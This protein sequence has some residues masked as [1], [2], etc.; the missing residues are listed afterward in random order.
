[1]TSLPRIYPL[2]HPQQRIFLVQQLNPGTPVWNV[3]YG[4]RVDGVFDRQALEAAVRS[5]VEEFDGLRV[6]ISERDGEVGHCIAEPGDIR[7][8]VITLEK[9]GGETQYDAWARRFSREPFWGFDKPLVQFVAARITSERWGLIVKLHH[10]IAD[11][12]G[13]LNAIS[14]V[15]E[16]Y[17]AITS[18]RAP[19]SLP[20]HS[21]CLA[22]LDY[23]N[24]YLA[25]QQVTVDRE[26]WLKEFAAVPD[27]IE[28]FPEQATPS[29]ASKRITVKM[30]DK[31]SADLYDFCDHNSTSP[32]RLLLASLYI[33]LARTSRT[34]DAVIGTALQN[35]DYP[36]M[37]D[38]VGMF[39]STVPI[40][41]T[42]PFES[43]FTRLLDSIKEKMSE[44]R[45]HERYPFDMLLHNIRERDG[46]VPELMQ[47]S[48]AQFMGKRFDSSTALEFQCRRAI[49]NP[50]NIYLLHG[51]KGERDVPVELIFDYQSAVFSEERITALAGHLCN[52][53]TAGIAAPETVLSS[54]NMLS[55]GEERRLLEQFNATT[56]EFPA[57]KTLHGLFEEQVMR[58]PD[59]PALV[60]REQSMSYA[61]LNARAD[62][63]A[64]MLRE[65]G[66]APDTIVGLLVDRSM[67]MIVG[68]LGI[69]K[70]GAGYAPID[71]QYPEDRIAY[72]LEDSQA[73]LLVTQ[74]HYVNK[75]GFTQKVINLDDP[76]FLSRK[77]DK[78]S[79]VGSP[80]NIACMIYTSGSTGNPKGVMLEQQ[81][82]VNIVQSHI[83]TRGMTE[84][85]R[86]AKLA[87]F[88][89]DASIIEIY[90]ALSVGA[91]LYIIP[92]EIRLNLVP[93][94]D[95][96][97][98]HGI[99]GAFFTTQLG[100][101]FMELFDNR[102]LRYLDVGGEKLRSFK[103]RNYQ[104]YN[105]YGP[106]ECSVYAT[107]FPVDREYA[108]IPIG[109]PLHN[110]CLYVVDSFNN[111]QPVGVPGELCI[112]GVALARGYWNLP[113]K[114][115]AA[116]V[117]NPFEPGQSRFSRLYRTGD[118]ARWL[119]DGTIEHLGRI[120]R[121][122]K[123]RGYRIEPGEIESAILSL[124]GVSECAVLDI[125]EPSGRVAL[126]AYVVA[127]RP[128]DG[129]TLKREI[130]TTLP[131]YMMPQYI[132]QMEAFPQTGSGKI[133]RKAFPKPEIMVQEETL[134]VAPRSELEER[135]AL[136]WQE[137]LK[138]Q[139][140]GIDDNF[141]SIGGQSLKAAFLLARMEKQVG[142]RVAMHEFFATPTIRE[143]SE[144]FGELEQSEV[145]RLEPASSAPYYP[146]TPSQEQLFILS[147]MDGIGISYNVPFRMVLDGLLDIARL[148]VALRHLLLRHESLRTLFRIEGNLPV[149][150]IDPRAR[151]DLRF[152]EGDEESVEQMARNFIRPFDLGK[153]PLFR[154]LLVKT[155]QQCH[156]LIMDLHH[157][158]CDGVSVSIL[159]RD[160]RSLYSGEEPPPLP[161]QFKDYA[162]WYNSFRDSEKA[163]RQGEFW[164]E[165]FHDPK[166][167]EMPTDYPRG[168]SASFEG[169]A[170][171]VVLE[172]DVYRDL[173]SLASSSGCTMHILLMAALH[174]L[175]GRYSRQ[176]DVT[177]GTTLAGRPLDET[178]DMIGMF[179]V[180]LPVRS[181]PKGGETFREFLGELKKTILSVHQ[182]QIYPMERLYET[183]NLRRGAGRHPL[184]DINLVLRNIDMDIFDADGV[185]GERFSIPTNTCKF[186]MSIAADELD[187]KIR[188]RIDYR[189]ALYDRSTVERFAGHYLNVLADAARNPDKQIADIAILSP[190]EQ[191][192][193]L[194]DFNP[195]P[196]PQPSWETV[197][198][199][200]RRHAAERPTRTALVAED[201]SLTYAELD[202]RSDTLARLLREKGV[203]TD[204]VT[205]IMADRSGMVVVAM[206]AI[207]KAGGA[208]TA[209][210]PKYPAERIRHIL[211]SADAQVLLGNS[212]V[213]AGV[214]FEGERIA[215][216]K[217]LPPFQGE[218]SPGQ[219]E[220]G[221]GGDVV[222]YEVSPSS[223]AYIIY[224]SGSTGKPKGV[225]VE[226]RSLVNFLNWYTTLHG[227]T[228]EDNSAAFASFSFD[229]C[230][231]QVWAPLVSGAALHVI[232]EELRLSPAEL[233]EYFETNSVT[234]AHFPTQF[235]EQFMAMTDNRS[236]KRLVVGGDALR[237]YRIGNYSIVNEYG[238]S[239]TTVASTAIT[240]DRQYA[241]VPIGKPA[242]NTRV[243]ILDS[244][245]KLQPVG[246]PGEICIAGSGLA[247]GYRNNPEQTAEKFVADPFAPGKIM[248]RTG[249]LGRWL[250]DGNLEFLG[251][252]DFQVKIRGFRIELS[253]IEQALLAVET[254]R[255]TVV[256]ARSDDDGNKY[257]C[258]YYEA[259][260]E[261][262]LT[263]LKQKLARS[264][265]DYMIPSALVW[266]AAMPINRNG[267]IDRP[268]LPD[269]EFSRVEGEVVPPG[270]PIEEDIAAAWRSVLKEWRGGI[271]DNFFEVGGDSLRA[272]ALVAQL[273]KNFNVRI[274]DI[275]A[276]PSI[277][278]QGRKL[279][280]VKDNLKQRLYR[281]KDALAAA[282]AARLK[283]AED[284][285]FKG[286]VSDY[287]KISEGF[288]KLDLTRQ[289]DYR[290]VLLTGSTGYLGCYILRELLTKR[291]CRLTL[292]IR[293]NSEIEAT[294]RLQGK[295]DYYFGAEFYQQHQARITVLAADL[296]K[297]RLGVQEAE[298]S[299]LA[300][301]I[302]C[303]IHAAANVRHYGLYEE[304]H[305]SNV[306]STE[307]LIE[308]ASEGVK[309]DIHHISTTST[310]QG[311]TDRPW[312]LFTED[313]LD[314]GQSPANVYV[315]SKLAAERLVTAAREKGINSCIH[316]VGNICYDS[317]SG[318]F[319]ENI[320]EN[321]FYQQVKGYADIGTAPD[322]GDERNLT[323][324]DR[325]AAAIVT[326]F[327]R[328]ELPDQIFHFSNPNRAKLSQLLPDRRLG[329]N[330][331]IV[332]QADFIDLLAE[333]FDIPYFSQ[334]IEN[335][336]LHQGWLDGDPAAKAT[337]LSIRTERTDRI[338]ELAGFSWPNPE[339][340]TIR[341]MILKALTERSQFLE[342]MPV[343]AH[344][345]ASELEKL[346]IHARPVWLPVETDISRE[347]EEEERIYAVVDGHLEAS[348]LSRDGWVG[349]IRL[350]SAGELIGKDALLHG[351]P[352]PVTIQSILDGVVLLEFE[353]ELLRSLLQDSPGFAL[354][355]AKTLSHSLN[356]MESLFVNMG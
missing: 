123:I 43:S 143:I 265:P 35:R 326:L 85:D 27:P 268:A 70:S 302:D 166:P 65:S 152:E 47:F 1:M 148:S 320:E 84:T 136:L 306:T 127:S 252:V 221:Q 235:A 251:R 349:T 198:H 114:T 83:M 315:K 96:Y 199:A 67:A 332:R 289:R 87:S 324:V 97:E 15:M 228:S 6:Y 91:T 90:P 217:Q 21:S 180:T 93:L 75:M 255:R 273:Q 347:G 77:S 178:A 147:R 184:F 187:G 116:F 40:R 220:S 104:L 37:A 334:P 18:G 74:G 61:E 183:L 28:L 330:L 243:Y 318:Q 263:E 4:V 38:I 300:S 95:Y 213:L 274:A 234:H 298:Y 36:G 335:L 344:L 39:V 212:A 3:P 109:R 170:C 89:F 73:T 51:A 303:I 272:I 290:H 314:I 291:T 82:L 181:Y 98:K 266:L 327:D 205:A 356:R 201:L 175:V 301:S 34:P 271:H 8:D 81:A 132:I 208:Y 284:L 52:I 240:V 138:L 343:F 171:H 120:D 33:W 207:L 66:A 22:Y 125:R 226:H 331:T 112:S 151:L 336:M 86:I 50:V 31:L 232:P 204:S 53:L 195:A 246:V 337:I 229:A 119:P 122:V 153:A 107:Q 196:T 351:L 262:P 292:P 209:V 58:T 355:M 254:I 210:D 264:L 260:A 319:Q 168:A 156:H 211:E 134:Y 139:R 276:Y 159:L 282:A 106:T 214:E 304:F 345:A 200:F 19:S 197:V 54:F 160:L 352:S 25:S 353:P 270:S 44:V 219:S 269:P 20:Q 278:Q 223:L 237:S 128:I 121:Q 30:P 137:V 129:G 177:T 294:L 76:L 16:H 224:T 215:L 281:L 191:H 135:I 313:D 105:A 62:M 45:G 88:S 118:L 253:E 124:E 69:L 202:S 182:N 113:E 144:T 305:A 280:P 258:A 46:E 310:G 230:V 13:A 203:G 296:I 157:I 165:L 140:V 340:E 218:T 256:L 158:V 322:E 312:A 103:K 342:R 145:E 321:A 338:L 244:N 14:G 325:C 247:R 261:I 56:A 285:A 249:D 48:V 257:L 275:F 174:L 329:L 333:R 32:F 225:M 233:S 308:L 236:L 10:I 189:T 283:L 146:L 309:K 164:H 194:I 110:Y 162:V 350:L 348:R 216:D 142:I 190:G 222:E 239:E 188:F 49:M 29:V 161:V 59:K 99:T 163:V 185:T 241:R 346:S 72:M 55:G 41:V 323:F 117:E 92:D 248:Y 141:F 149:Q 297:P 288:E 57:G 316:R 238:P 24:E 192:Q 23:E 242:D 172:R 299:D 94:N 259:D 155:G 42:V 286:A 9:G 277:A 150:M 173:V 279:E 100:E 176:E 111:L 167:S 64:G 250:P 12:T 130:G 7:L 311:V 131:E 295:L 206:L 179:V 126:C 341:R 231:A 227:F 71:P 339:P 79:P 63:L 287:Q 17:N 68:A 102:S 267:K 186:D 5:T 154:V 354:G 108:N 78:L 193:L 115:A 245:L 80:Q 101:Q 26:F 169:D 317:I 2:T 11:G 60:Y 293:G 133:D 307:H 328:A